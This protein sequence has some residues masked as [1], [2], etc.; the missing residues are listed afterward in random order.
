M[1]NDKYPNSFEENLHGIPEDGIGQ[2]EPIQPEPIQ[3]E[4]IQPNQYSQV[5]QT[6]PNAYNHQRYYNQGYQQPV[7]E[8]SCIGWAIL[9]FFFPLVGFILFLVWRNTKPKASKM[10]GIGA[11]VGF[12]LGLISSIGTSIASASAAIGFLC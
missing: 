10:S 6:Q 3:A 4:P 9:G 5:N 8:G 2:G 11:L 12:G 7:Q 1:N